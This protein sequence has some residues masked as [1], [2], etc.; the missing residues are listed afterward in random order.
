M[1][2][3]LRV[4]RYWLPPLLW[5]AFIFYL[6]SDKRGQVSDVQAINFLFFKVLHVIWYSILYFLLFRAFY[7]LQNKSM[8]LK[9]KM[10]FAF[11]IAVFYGA[12]DEI[13]QTFVPG[14]EGTVRDACIDALG[15]SITYFYV[16]KYLH[17][18]KRYL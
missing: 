16:K 14:R 17:F 13:H 10:L 5:M 4:I 12:T 18:F 8:T 7:S 6:S 2:P 15:I 9:Q 11:L 1:K 3:F